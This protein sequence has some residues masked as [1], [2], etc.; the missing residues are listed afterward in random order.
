MEVSFCPSLL[1][2]VETG[3]KWPKPESQF[4]FGKRGAGERIIRKNLRRCVEH[5][6]RLSERTGRNLHL[7]FEPEPLCL[8]ENSGET[9]RF[10]DRLRG[11][12]PGDPRLIEHLGVNYDACHLSNGLL[13]APMRRS[14]ESVLGL[15]GVGVAV[16]MARR[17]LKSRGPD[18]SADL[19]YIMLNTWY[20]PILM[21]QIQLGQSPVHPT[22]VLQQ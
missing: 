6:A 19:G 3:L 1:P 7:G 20:F 10:F 16:K 5:I 17:E 22:V 13:R 21:L 4:D 2:K 8:L 9:I 14:A 15:E 12:H 18:P 11:E